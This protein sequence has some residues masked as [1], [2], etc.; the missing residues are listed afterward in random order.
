MFTLTDLQTYLDDFILYDKNLH[1]EK[2]DP[3]M[4]NGL[5]VRGNEEVVKIGF[6][7][8]ASISLFEKAKMERC[9]VIIVHHAFNYPPYNRF[10]EIFQGRISYLLQNEISLFGYHFLL[11][12][13]PE[14]GNNVQ[15]IKN[16]GAKPTK[17]YLHRGNPWGWVGEYEKSIDFSEVLRFLKPFMSKE[18]TIYD[19]G[20]KKVKRI[21]AVSG[22]GA[23][24]PS[25]MQE[26]MDEKIDLFVTGEVHEWNRELCRE[27]DINFIAGG[28]YATEKFGIQA[29]MAK[30]QNHFKNVEVRWLEL[31]NEV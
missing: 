9:N 11:D 30:I 8:S 22:K 23:P 29:L 7:V 5:M 10:D 12:A 13:H 19:L 17:P 28:H 27:A 20:P 4:A 31:E 15:I 2:I 6:G 14:V 1:L 26:L 21:V 24:F 18:S 16:L 3:H 25:D